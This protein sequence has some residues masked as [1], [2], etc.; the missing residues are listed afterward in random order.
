MTTTNEQVV[1]Y[2]VFTLDS[3]GTEASLLVATDSRRLAL[4]YVEAAELSDVSLRRFECR[5][6]LSF[7]AQRAALQERYGT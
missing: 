2:A 3:E 1:L 4:E 6:W 7:K 5:D